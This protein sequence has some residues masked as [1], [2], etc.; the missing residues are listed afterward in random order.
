ME[1]LSFKNQLRY[2][3]ILGNSNKERVSSK[4]TLTGT[5]QLGHFQGPVK[6]A[7]TREVSLFQEDFSV[8]NIYNMVLACIVIFSGNRE[9]R[10]HW[11]QPFCLL[12]SS[13]H[14]GT[15]MYCCYGK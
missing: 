6:W 14:K 7:L 12:L 1:V 5:S 3:S 4:Q 15:K 9:Q 2:G 10:T 11:N 8:L 13:S